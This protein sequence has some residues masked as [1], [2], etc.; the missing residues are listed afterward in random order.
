MLTLLWLRPAR[1]TKLILLTLAFSHKPQHYMFD[2]ASPTS[3]APATAAPP[4]NTS[5]S[6]LSPEVVAS[7]ENLASQTSNPS[8]ALEMLKSAANSTSTN[9][10]GS[11]N[12]ARATQDHLLNEHPTRAQMREVHE[13]QSQRVREALE[14]HFQ[15]KQD[16]DKEMEEMR[17]EWRTYERLEKK[18]REKKAKSGDVAMTGT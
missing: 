17:L 18:M 11:P 9:P 12:S 15:T 3:T 16:A 10:T 1:T 2:M 6:G 5:P 13:R 8:L 7:L 4:T 14:R